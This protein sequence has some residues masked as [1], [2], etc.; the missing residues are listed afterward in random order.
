MSKLYNCHIIQFEVK[1]H[2]VHI[3]CART[4]NLYF[5]VYA[6]LNLLL[7][8]TA[9]FFLFPSEVRSDGITVHF[10]SFSCNLLKFKL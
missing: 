4:T 10:P 2:Y 1:E 6:L 8:S 5:R 3:F 9:V 7:C